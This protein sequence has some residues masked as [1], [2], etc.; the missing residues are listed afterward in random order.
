[1]EARIGQVQSVDKANRT[2]RA[3]FKDAGIMSGEL[4]VLRRQSSAESTKYALTGE[5]SHRHQTDWFPEIDDNILV[6]YVDGF[7]ADG[8]CVGVI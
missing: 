3:Y 8:I 7:N 6:V 2:V 4:K 5:Y 1:M